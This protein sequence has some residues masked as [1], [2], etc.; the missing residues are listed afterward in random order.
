MPIKGK[1][2]F[3]EELTGV[4]AS[5]DLAIPDFLRRVA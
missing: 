4:K 5:D 3:L 1:R 2:V